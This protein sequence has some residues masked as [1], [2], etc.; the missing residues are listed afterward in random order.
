MSIIML[1]ETTT[2]AH[3]ECA[4]CEKPFRSFAAFHALDKLQQ[5]LREDGWL[6][7]KAQDGHGRWHD[8]T[9]CSAAC[10]E[11]HMRLMDEASF[12]G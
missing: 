7:R 5:A 10:R 1:E 11:E 2:T 8:V 3:A 4:Q 6:L 9:Y 12:E